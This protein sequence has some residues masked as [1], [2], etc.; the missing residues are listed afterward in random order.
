M[1][2]TTFVDDYSVNKRIKVTEEDLTSKLE[3]IK[4]DIDLFEQDLDT[5]KCEIE[6]IESDIY[7]CFEFIKDVRYNFMLLYGM[8][9]LINAIILA[10]IFILKWR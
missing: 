1:Y 5:I 9:V 7:D 8:T 3:P 10:S 4:K 6:D 2:S